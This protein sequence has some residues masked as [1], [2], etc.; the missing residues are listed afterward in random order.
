MILETELIAIITIIFVNDVFLLNRQIFDFL[1]YFFFVGANNLGFNGLVGVV[2]L[3]RIRQP[4][5]NDFVVCF[6]LFPDIYEHS[7]PTDLKFLGIRERL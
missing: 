5:T 1:V 6:Y 7:R 4:R 2:V 3:A